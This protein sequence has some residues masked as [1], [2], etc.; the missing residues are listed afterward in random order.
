M[1][2]PRPAELIERLRALPP[3]RPLLE[4]V[5]QHAGVYLVGGAVRD[6]LRDE[7]P[8]ELDLVVEG[9]AIELAKQ[10]GGQL[11]RYERFGTSTVTIDG[12]SYDIAQAR[13]ETYSRPGALP[14][15][16]PAPLEVDLLRRDFTV[17]AIALALGEPQAG[18]VTAAPQAL[19]DLER[20]TLRVLHEE[21]FLDDP[22]RL[23]RLARYRSRLGF[24]IEPLTAQLSAAAVSGGALAT[25][26]GSRIGAELRLLAGEPDPLSALGA[27][28]ELG[29]GEAIH[30]GFGLRDVELA[31]RAVGLLPSGTRADRLVLALAAMALGAD[32]LRELLDQLAF[33]AEDRDTILATVTRARPV[34]SELAAAQR[35]SE[36]SG[37]VRG[38]PPELVA[39]AGA[40]GPAQAAQ[41]WLDRLRHVHLDI[42]GG[43]LLAAGVPEGP[44]VG[45]GLRAAL[46]AKLDGRAE[47]PEEQLRAALRAAEATG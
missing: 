44:A 14:D 35:P 45:R 9:D 12:F 11:A 21:S 38:A 8:T 26:S 40:L 41:E 20:Q 3:G 7:T 32:E 15:V 13:R 19:E 2:I 5:P 18:K 10:L 37:A 1:E 25:V 31:H 6:L 16:A 43:D 39:L 46:A 36:I 22:T 24:D 30:A 23:L 28:R 42:D 4:R 47:G 27:L 29:V 34:A 17:N 33:E